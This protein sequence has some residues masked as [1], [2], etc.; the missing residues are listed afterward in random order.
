MAA[1]SKNLGLLSHANGFN[2]Y[3]YDTE[4][5][6]NLVEAVGYFNN[7]DDNLDLAVGD[8]VMVFEWTVA[9]GTRGQSGVTP[10]ETGILANVKMFVV[11]NVQPRS[12]ATLAGD[13]N[14]AE[15]LISTAGAISSKD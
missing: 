12:A 7:V 2:S 14:L 13:V 15:I 1:I 9:I 6:A 3:R 11:T 5:Q 10:V 4:D 8:T